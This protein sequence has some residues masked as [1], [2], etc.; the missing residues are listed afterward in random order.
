M[1]KNQQITHDELDEKA[2]VKESNES[3]FGKLLILSP[4]VQCHRVS[5]NVMNFKIVGGSITAFSQF[6]MALLGYIYFELK[7]RKIGS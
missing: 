1:C 6:A 2:T 5:L 4:T 3:I 7:M